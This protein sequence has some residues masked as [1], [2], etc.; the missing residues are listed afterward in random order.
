MRWFS[1]TPAPLPEGEGRGGGI[2]LKRNKKTFISPSRTIPDNPSVPT[3]YNRPSGIF[4][5]P[6]PLPYCTEILNATFHS[7]IACAHFDHGPCAG[8]GQHLLERRQPGPANVAARQ[9]GRA[10]LP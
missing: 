6:A 2:A 5:G 8:A 9:Q 7:R 4:R 1:L 3:W 10:V